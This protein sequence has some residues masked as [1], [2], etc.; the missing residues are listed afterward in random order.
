MKPLKLI[1]SAF[2]P[3][4]GTQEVDFTRFGGRGLFLITGDTGAGKTTV[5]DGITYALFGEASGSIRGGAELRSDFAT[6][7]T[8]TYALL[9]FEHRGQEYT[10]RRSPEYERPKL[11]GEGLTRQPAYA[12]LTLPDGKTV[13]KV[14]EVT[15]AV[16]ELLRIN[17]PQFKQLCMLAQGEFL[18]LLLASSSE[19]TEI[20]R[21]I[22]DTKIFSLIQRELFN[23]ERKYKQAFLEVQHSILENCERISPG[24]DLND[25]KNPLAQALETLESE[26]VYAAPKL[27]QLLEDQIGLDAQAW[28][29]LIKE[30]EAIDKQSQAL[31]VAF[32]AAKEVEK[33]KVQLEQQLSRQHEIENYKNEIKKLH[34]DI[35]NIEKAGELAADHALLC[36][37][38]QQGTRA[39]REVNQLSLQYKEL[40][41][42]AA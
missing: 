19:R 29:D 6:A 33:K 15:K 11:R 35:A 39:E 21:K 34:L 20:F 13:S 32:E 36:D 27:C 31:A 8:D 25:Q 5:F 2:G 17:M 28:D 24:E 1:L 22:F 9:K 37:G 26:G 18:K 41:E 38:R 3:Y 12:E 30:K 10:V 7:Q 14:N 42:A 40:G 16:E 23:E 4:A